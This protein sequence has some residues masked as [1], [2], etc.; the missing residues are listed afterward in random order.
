[1]TLAERNA[2]ARRLGMSYGKYMA[3]YHPVNPPKSAAAADPNAR[4]C[5]GCGEIMTVAH[6]KFCDDKCRKN[7]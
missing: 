2:E 3:K 5:Q 1:M 6:R 4:R 7:A